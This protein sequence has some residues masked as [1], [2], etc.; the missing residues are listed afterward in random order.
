[1]YIDFNLAMIILILSVVI[2]VIITILVFL[3]RRERL[4]ESIE[5]LQKIIKT[6]ALAASDGVV[7]KEELAEMFD[8]VKRWILL[9]FAE[10]NVELPPDPEDIPEPP[11]GSPPTVNPR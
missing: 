11:T 2:S 1:M 7:T 9:V 8:L 5:L 3:Y 6:S 4:P 10:K